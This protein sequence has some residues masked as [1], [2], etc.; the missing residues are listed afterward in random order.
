MVTDLRP[1]LV[2]E[3][4]AAASDARDAA[5]AADRDPTLAVHELRKALRRARA[6]LALLHDALPRHD[7]RT[8]LH[9]LRDARREVGTAR[10][11]AVA[12]STLAELALSPEE[13]DAAAA[14]LA[15]TAAATP[16]KADIAQALAEGAALTAAQVEIVEA[17]LPEQLAWPTVIAGLSAVYRD[18]RRARRDAKHRKRA[19]HRWR[20]RTKELAYQLELLA[21]HAGPRLDQLAREIAGIAATQSPAVDLL[22]IRELV[23]THERQLGEQTS[24]HLIDAIDDHLAPLI[25]ASRRAGREAFRRKPRALARYLSKAIDEDLNPG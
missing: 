12:P 19:F 24:D 13:R 23:R 25:K 10:D 5:S 11:H 4:R 21:R 2:D 20:R 7:R 22:M 18:A 15:E 17:V 14:L 6:V 3:L 1:V 9:A 16:P 8:V